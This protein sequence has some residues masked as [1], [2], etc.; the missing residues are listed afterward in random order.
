MGLAP[1]S[2]LTASYPRTLQQCDSCDEQGAHF[3]TVELTGKSSVSGANIIVK[4][5]VS[6][7]RKIS[8]R[9]K[10]IFAAF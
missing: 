10:L 3:T 8:K 5:H 1:Y 2:K 9:S 4:I 7:I 6:V